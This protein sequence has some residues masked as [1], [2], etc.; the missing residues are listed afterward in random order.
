MLEW[1][2]C[3][4]ISCSNSPS[5]RVCWAAKPFSLGGGGGIMFLKSPMNYETVI[6]KMRKMGL[7]EAKIHR[8]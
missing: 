5:K 4:E 6:C 1:M 7:E 2:L 8:T 3:I